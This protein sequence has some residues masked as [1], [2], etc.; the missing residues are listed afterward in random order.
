MSSYMEAEVRKWDDLFYLINQPPHSLKTA[1]ILT[2]YLATLATN[3]ISLNAGA[4]QRGKYITGQAKNNLIP[5]L[6]EAVQF[7][8]MGGM[9]AIKPYVKNGS[10]FVEII[11]RSRIF[12]I[13]FGAN[14]RIETG[15]FTDFEQIGGI[16]YVRLERFELVKEGLRITNKVYRVKE[17]ELLGKEESLSVSPRWEQLNSDFLIENVDRPHFGLIRMPTV[18]TIDGSE[19]PVSVYANAIDSI[20]ELDN[21]YRQFLWERDTGKRRMLIDRTAALKNPVNGKSTIPFKELASDYYMTMDMPEDKP[22]DDYTPEMRMESYQKAFDIQLRLLEMQTGFSAGTFQIDIKTGRVTA[23]QIIS[24]DKTT[25]NTVK[26]VQDRGMTVG[27][28]DVMYWFDIYASLYGLTPSGSV[29]FSVTFGDSIFEDT[30]IEFQRRKAMADSK[31]IRPELL[32]SWYFG[33]SEKE[34]ADMLPE[35]ETPETIM[36]G[37]DT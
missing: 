20:M 8:G 32:T 22:W 34:A 14:K 36:F 26:A 11:P 1:Q 33:I 35:A 5:N 6:W 4:S 29:D 24:E 31:Y 15:F 3:E 27:L 30:G 25:Y 37:R 18:N 21:T 19:F 23:T 17:G 28:T 7:A 9:S 16:R 12:P 2:A 10:V 13:K